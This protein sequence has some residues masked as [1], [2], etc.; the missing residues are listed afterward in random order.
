M[1]RER[2]PSTRT[3]GGGSSG[4]LGC[5]YML[6]VKRPWIALHL[7]VND[8]IVIAPPLATSGEENDPQCEPARHVRH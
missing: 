1:H 4:S 8:T 3:S 2:A 5:F 7:P 6:P